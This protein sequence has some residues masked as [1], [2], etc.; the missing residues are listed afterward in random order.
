[1]TTGSTV[2]VQ[3]AILDHLS[4]PAANS[5]F[6]QRVLADN[7][8]HPDEKGSIRVIALTLRQISFAWEMING[9]DHKITICASRGS[10]GEYMKGSRMKVYEAVAET[11]SRL[12]VDTTFGLVGSGNFGLVSF[13]L[14]P[15][16]P[17]LGLRFLHHERGAVC[18]RAGR[19]AVHSEPLL[20]RPPA[21]VS[22]SHRGLQALRTSARRSAFGT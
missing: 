4:V 20:Q 2:E 19:P 22:G 9:P 10:E 6:A 5:G 14:D 12:G 18:V 8:Q 15:G 1:M 13:H 16:S 11:L 7:D 17:D 3:Q 21:H